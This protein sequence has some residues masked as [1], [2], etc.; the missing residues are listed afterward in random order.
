VTLAAGYLPAR[1]AAR[2]DPVAVLA[3]EWLRRAKTGRV[4]VHDSVRFTA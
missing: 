4:L 3:A 1:R 2:V